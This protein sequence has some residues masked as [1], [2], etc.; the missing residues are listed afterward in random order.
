VYSSTSD[1][2]EIRKGNQHGVAHAMSRS[3]VDQGIANMVHGGPGAGSYGHGLC[4]VCSG[5][6]AGPPT[7]VVYH[8]D[9]GPLATSN[10]N[11]TMKSFLLK[12]LKS[13]SLRLW[14]SSLRRDWKL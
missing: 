11:R 2:L 14:A 8:V 7:G 9:Q 5:E 3:R 4:A 13:A 10:G 6:I 12:N 1:L